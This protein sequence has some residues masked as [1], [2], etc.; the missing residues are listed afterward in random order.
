[1]NR[2]LSLLALS[3]PVMTAILP[4]GAAA[5]ARPSASKPAT[6]QPAYPLWDGNESVAD[7]AKRAGIKDVQVTLALDGNVTMKLTLIPA[8]RF[9]MG[10]PRSERLRVDEY[11]QH[12]VTISNPHYMGVYVVTQSQWRTVLGTGV[13]EQ[14]DKE[15]N[16]WP[17]GSWPLAGVS[18][19][20]PMY[21]VS[22]DEANQFC[23][24][25]SQKVGKVVR[26]PTEAEWEYACRAGTRTRFWFG[27]DAN[28]LGEFAWFLKNSDAN[29]HPVGQKKPN[30]WGLYD[31][32]GNVFQWC[33]DWYDVSYGESPVVD[34]RGPSASTGRVIRGGSWRETYRGCRSASRTSSAPFARGKDIGFRVVVD[35]PAA[36]AVESPSTP[37]TNPAGATT[38]SPATSQPVYPLWD[39]NESVADYAKRAGIKDVQMTLPLDGNVTMKLTLIPAGKFT[40]G[41]P[42]S[43]KGHDE[44]EGPQHEVT[45]SRP[46]YMGVYEVT[47]NQYEQIMGKNPSA[48]KEP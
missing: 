21:Y 11:P 47:Q 33:A 44:Y 36:R 27:D 39:G 48:F 32:H 2:T 14:R 24:T 4:N 41:S 25:L 9:L 1:M 6:T 16:S 20:S 18:A 26:L 46:F 43:E 8:G 10:S 22:W 31:I 34:P 38:S 28:N 29:S 45:I 37:A 35:L 5:S 30:N 42:D 12:E 40:M 23:V 17:S 13:H 3:I 7:Y 15:S 19:D